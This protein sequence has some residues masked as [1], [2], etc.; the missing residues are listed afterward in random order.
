MEIAHNDIKRPAPFAGVL[1]QFQHNE[2]GHDAY[3]MGELSKSGWW[4]FFPLAWLW[5]STPVELLLTVISL[6]LLPFLWGDLKRLVRPVPAPVS[7]L[8]EE[9]ERQ[10]DVSAPTSHAPLI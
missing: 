10:S 2:A 6:C 9:D 1:F 3:L 8:P 5:K 4:Y 7:E